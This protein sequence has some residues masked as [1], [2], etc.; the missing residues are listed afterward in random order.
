MDNLTALNTAESLIVDNASTNWCPGELALNAIELSESVAVDIDQV[1]VV[2]QDR[3]LELRVPE[4][5][6]NNNE[7]GDGDVCRPIFQDRL[8][9]VEVSEPEVQTIEE[10]KLT[11]FIRNYVCMLAAILLLLVFV[12]MFVYVIV[13]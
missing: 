5:A 3:P 9:Q 8:N 2:N 4:H 1:S 12:M 10:D 6:E 7:D 11:A 13:E